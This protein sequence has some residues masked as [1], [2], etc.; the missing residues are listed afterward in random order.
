MSNIA[1]KRILFI[2]PQFFGYEQDIEK[3]LRHQG[4][5][6]DFLPDRPFQSPFMKGLTRVRRELILNYAERYFWS[7]ISRFGRASYDLIFVVL[8]ECV[9]P[10][11]LKN[12]RQSFPN[13]TFTLYMWDSFKNRKALP[14]NIEY[15]DCCLTFDF[16]D[17]K[18]YG[19]HFRPLFYSGGFNDKDKKENFKYDISFIGTAHSDRY[20]IVS[21]VIHNLPPST[22]KYFYLYLQASWV[23]WI[24][25]LGDSDFR[26]AKVQ[27]F[28]YFPITKAQVQSVFSE[29]RAI[30]DIEHPEQT[31][32]TM[33]TFETL[34][35][36]KKLITTNQ[37]VR[38]Y[39]FFNSNNILIIDRKKVTAIPE[40]FLI[41]PYTPLSDQLYQK[42]S[43]S[44][45]LDDI[46]GN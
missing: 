10:T 39:D 37:S 40:N 18:N 11:F 31:G 32:L 1:S 29:S 35:A 3:E 15:F 13:A 4:A 34:G 45:W 23:F 38:E 16:D 33:R 24:R 2:A 8:G 25:K 21:D 43:I 20:R 9:S 7:E 14:K 28:K 41:E 22:K 19:M 17:A 30:L 5:E 44:G 42:Y 12:L 27:D 46:F 36:Q 26:G 6:V